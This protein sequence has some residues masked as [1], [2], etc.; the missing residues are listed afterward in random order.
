MTTNS[1]ST[2]RV[3][4]L[5]V[6]GAT[7]YYEVRGS[8]PVLLMIPGGPADAGA[9]WGI[10]GLLA[11]WYTVVTYD[12]RG[13]SRSKLDGPP[14]DQKV[15]VH[16]DDAHRLLAAVGA[17][18]AYVLG[19][20]GGAVVGLELVARHPG[21]VDALV[22]HEPP[23]LELL[24]DA[25][26]WRAFNQEVYDT[27]RNDGVGPAM[28]K[29]GAG[30][31]IEDQGPPAEMPPEMMEGMA[32]M[33]GNIE[34]FVAH[35]IRPISGYVPDIAALWATSTRIVVAAGDESRAKPWAVYEASVA[36]AE[37]LGTDVVHFPGHHGGFGTHPA[38]FAE[39]LHE[40][41]SGD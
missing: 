40:V 18:P 14:A 37:R 34:F 2:I 30:L 20:S 16:A 27:Y 1:P 19:S 24:P 6:P 11:D 13:N 15:E 12:P 29:F 32:R 35:L 31:G 4:S 38:A 39:K 3:E 33:G 26:R 41:L 25:A 9:F 28:Q 7:L 10:A 5:K 21:Q 23:V 36:L 22:A 8:G 17:E